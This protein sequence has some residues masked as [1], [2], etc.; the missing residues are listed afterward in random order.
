MKAKQWAE[1]YRIIQ[2]SDFLHPEGERKLKVMPEGLFRHLQKSAKELI[3]NN[4]TLPAYHKVHLQ[5]IIDGEVPY[6]M[7]LETKPGKQK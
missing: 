7:T 6:G 5:S 2:P 3:A 1:F 4:P